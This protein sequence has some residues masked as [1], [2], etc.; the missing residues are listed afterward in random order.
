MSEK[1]I[2]EL[3]AE[4]VCDM[5]CP[6]SHRKRH[7]EDGEPTCCAGCASTGGFWE[8]GE[9]DSRVTDGI[10]T[11]KEA[12]NILEILATKNVGAFDK[13]T[14]CRLERKMRSRVCLQWKCDRNG[15]PGFVVFTGKEQGGV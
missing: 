5:Q 15:K 14:G 4:P 3:I 1:T 12:D 8:D 13:E 2:A 6:L 9:L 10:I 11:Q 7:K